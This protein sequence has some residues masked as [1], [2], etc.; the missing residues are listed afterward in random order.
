[1]GQRLT[2]VGRPGVWC[3]ELCSARG[4]SGFGRVRWEGALWVLDREGGCGRKCYGKL[5]GGRLTRG[6]WNNPSV[7]WVAWPPMDVWG[8]P[9]I[10]E[11]GFHVVH[12]SSGLGREEGRAGGRTLLQLVRADGERP[13][14]A[15]WPGECVWSCLDIRSSRRK[16]TEGVLLQCP[17][18]RGLDRLRTLAPAHSPHTRDPGHLFAPFTHSHTKLLLRLSPL[19]QCWP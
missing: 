4:C 12:V 19:L 7:G 15:F 3:R 10:P 13:Q 18:P 11:R 16:H 14:A 5:A 6:R 9:G 2:R 17:A 8:R 1:M